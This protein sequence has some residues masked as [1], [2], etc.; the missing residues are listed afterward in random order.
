MDL[1]EIQQKVESGLLASLDSAETLHKQ[2]ADS[3]F[4]QL[5][6]LPVAGDFTDNLKN[7]HDGA[8]STLYEFARTANRMG[9]EVA[10][11]ILERAGM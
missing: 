8:A 1:R 10:R 3:A 11:Q 2:V 4:Q 9:G 6:T 7:A 5:R